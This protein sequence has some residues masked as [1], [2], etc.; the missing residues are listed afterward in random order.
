MYYYESFRYLETL[1]MYLE[2]IVKWEVPA[3][4]GVFAIMLQIH[5]ITNRLWVEHM[6]S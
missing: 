2:N 6:L 3:N 4:V 1:V 5:K